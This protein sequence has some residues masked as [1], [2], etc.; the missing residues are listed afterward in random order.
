VGVEENIKYPHTPAMRER[1]Y[2]VVL[3]NDARTLGIDL[4]AA[5]ITNAVVTRIAA[6]GGGI[7]SL[8]AEAIRLL[9]GASSERGGGA[10]MAIVQKDR[11][12]RSPLFALGG[13]GLLEQ[14]ALNVVGQMTPH[15][16]NRL[17][18]CV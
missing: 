3:G 18:Q 6:A 9:Y 5:Q 14:A 17:A 2:F 15:F 13:H 8:A 1:E 16:D 7:E 11:Q 4:D 10:G 12:L